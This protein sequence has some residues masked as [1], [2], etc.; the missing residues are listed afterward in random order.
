MANSLIIKGAFWNIFERI[1]TQ[2]ISIIFTIILA[3]LISVEDYGIVAITTV[4]IT[5][6]SVIV[7]G[8][9]G[10]A[11]IQRKDIDDK[12]LSTVYYFNIGISMILLVC[13]VISSKII[14]EFYGVPILSTIINILA[15]KLPISAM[16]SL[17]QAILMRKLQFNKFFYTSITSM[18]VTGIIG[19]SLAYFG[20][21]I[22]ALVIQDIMN[23]L[24]TFLILNYFTKWYPK[25]YFSIERL[26]SLFGF[27]SKLLIQSLLN[28][29]FS[30]IRTLL[31]GKYYSAQDLALYNKGIQYPNLIVSNIDTAISRALFPIMSKSQNEIN[32]IKEMA[33]KV[34]RVSSY[35]LAPLLIGLFI[36]AEEFTQILLTEKWLGMVPYLRIICICLLIRA[37]QTALL[38]SIKSIGRSDVV[39]KMDVP[40]RIFGL[41]MLFISIKFGMLYIALSE[42]VVESIVLLVYMY[43]GKKLIEYGYLEVIKDFMINN[44]LAIIMGIIVY[45]VGIKFYNMYYKVLIQI[46]IG[47]FVYILLS[48]LTKNEGYKIIKSILIKGGK[49]DI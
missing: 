11:V 26:R 48:K 38:Q 28:V 34:T 31:I 22:W 39:L 1:G 4:I 32:K 17:H 42:I 49:H 13:I 21:G 9:F 41:L 46:V 10:A 18:L 24:V 15:I 25:I 6:F 7:D 30:N 27:G 14:S 8:G 29:L 47:L 33:S 20:Y 44:I 35:F 45:F 5:V 2:T 40:V 19:I 12:D 16:I 36:I 43:Y 23:A 37:P 3:R